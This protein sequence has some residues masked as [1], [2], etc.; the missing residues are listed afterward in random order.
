VTIGTTVDNQTQIL[1]G[2][3][4]GDRVFVK[5]PETKSKP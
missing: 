4:V 1:S 5:L 2:A 3:K